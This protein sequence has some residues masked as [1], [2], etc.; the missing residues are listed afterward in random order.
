MFIQL[1]TIYFKGPILLILA[2]VPL[3]LSEKR[4]RAALTFARKG[5]SGLSTNIVSD[6]TNLLSIFLIKF[7]NDAITY[8]YRLTDLHSQ[9]CSI[10]M[11]KIKTSSPPWTKKDRLLKKYGQCILFQSATFFVHSPFLPFRQKC[12][13]VFS[14]ALCVLHFRATV[15]LQSL[16]HFQSDFN[17]LHLC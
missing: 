15:V 16:Y 4:K 12:V 5:R 1:A 3:Y 8:I 14:L 7:F 13:C 9:N 10:F 17:S 11:E 2:K 6:W